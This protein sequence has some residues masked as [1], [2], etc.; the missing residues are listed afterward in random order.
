MYKG[1]KVAVV[2]GGGGLKPFAAL[3][4]FS[5]LKENGVEIDLLVGNSG[6]AILSSAIGSGYS[7]EY[8]LEKVVPKINKSLFIRNWRAILSFANLPFG[9]M[10]RHSALF[11]PDRLLSLMKEFLS[12]RKIEDLSPRTVFQATDYLTGENVLLE[13]G[14]LVKSVYASSAIYPFLPPIQI[15]G[16]WLFDGGYTAPIPVLPAIRFGADVIIVVDF[17]EK[18]QPDPK[19]AFNAIMHITKILTKSIAS[20]QMALSINLMDAELFYIKVNF[21][22]YISIWETESLPAILEAGQLAVDKAKNE[23]KLILQLP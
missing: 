3:P 11:K 10:E 17:F 20:N 14:D 5:F 6:G 21:E 16:R 22:K 19:G 12:D 4:L 2:L 13:K 18:I 7:T 15:D 23:L 8:I 9:K 1:K